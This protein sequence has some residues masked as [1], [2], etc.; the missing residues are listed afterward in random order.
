[1]V[2]WQ[3]EYTWGIFVQPLAFILFF[4]AAIAEQK[5]IPFDLPEAESELVS[6]YFTEYSGMKFGMFYFAEY[7]EVVTSSMLIVTIFL[8]GW[9]LPFFHRDGLT[10]AFGG[11][12][13]LRLPISHLA[14]VLI[15]I[16]AFF[17]KVVI[18]CLFQAVI[19]WSLPRFRYDQLMKLGWRVLLPAS[20]A[21]IMVTGVVYLAIDQAS[22]GFQEG[23]RMA[24]EVTQGLV[25]IVLTA[26]VVSL[27]VFMFQ[28]TRRKQLVLGSSARLSAALGGTRETPMQA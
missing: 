7:M 3:S 11:E 10:V 16:G 27:V 24:A 26:M 18:V 2:R 9:A 12:T 23:M 25:A 21:N 15:N 4:V 20:L 8:G 17:G 6:G 1:M 28:P 22:P 19:R 13:L 14:M 5:R